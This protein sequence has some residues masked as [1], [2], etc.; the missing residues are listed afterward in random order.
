[1]N[2]S[3]GVVSSGVWFGLFWQSFPEKSICAL[4]ASPLGKRLWTD[5]LVRTRIVL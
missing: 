1:M 3:G 5:S 2:L 4:S